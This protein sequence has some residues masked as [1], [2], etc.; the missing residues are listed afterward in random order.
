[1][2]ALYISFVLVTDYMLRENLMTANGR[3]IITL[4]G[5][6]YCHPARVREMFL[7][8]AGH[9]VRGTMGSSPDILGFRRTFRKKTPMLDIFNIQKDIL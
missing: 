3:G 6:A 2:L 9:F 5:R 8:S 1:M 7:S 4:T